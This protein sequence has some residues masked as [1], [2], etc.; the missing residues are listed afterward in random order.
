MIAAEPPVVSGVAGAAPKRPV[1]TLFGSVSL[2][3]HTGPAASASEVVTNLEQDAQAAERSG[4]DGVTISEHHAG[5]PGYMPQPM[6]AANWVLG[7]TARVWAGPMPWLLGLRN[8]ALVAEEL[9]W[10]AARFPNRL[11][12]A[13]APGYADSDHVAVGVG[14]QDRAARNDA[15]LRSLVDHVTGTG[16]LADDPAIIDLATDPG[17]VPLLVAANS[18]I[19]VAR[20]AELNLGVLFP[21]REEPL[22]LARLA[23]RYRELGGVGPLV[24]ISGVWCSDGSRSSNS[25]DRIV[26]PSHE[27]AERLADFCRTATV[28]A[29]NVRVFDA[30]APRDVALEQILAVGEVVAPFVR[31]ALRRNTP[32]S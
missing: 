27:V 30:T 26:G 24:A 20:A 15:S 14:F 23:A 2:G 10:T 32:A 6:L 7:Q 31:D 21:G 11:V 4:F 29:V 12:A 25:Q 22:R 9:A 16:P 28:D 13:F 17:T 1:A 5:F 8:P 19:G 18:A 3:L